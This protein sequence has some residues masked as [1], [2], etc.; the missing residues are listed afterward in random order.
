M[1]HCSLLGI[2]LQKT[3][4]CLVTCI[5]RLILLLDERPLAEHLRITVLEVLVHSEVLQAGVTD[6]VTTDVTVSLDITCIVILVAETSVLLVYDNTTHLTR[7]IR[8]TL[9]CTTVR[10]SGVGEDIHRRTELI[11]KL[12]SELCNT[13]CVGCICITLVDRSHRTLTHRE[14]AILQL[15]IGEDI[16]IGEIL[17]IHLL[18][19]NLRLCASLHI[20]N[21]RR[22]DILQPI[23]CR[24]VRVRNGRLIESST[25][26]AESNL[27]E[28]VEDGV[29]LPR[30]NI[31]H[32]TVSTVL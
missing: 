4:S 31:E 9:T 27:V 8:Q 20:H 17:D 25:T 24:V 23:V 28:A 10:A 1:Q 3:C 13:V 2:L 15:N 12:D 16:V 6:L 5:L 21:H 7:A 11:H 26:H 32:N 19:R 30:N 18:L 22:R 29:I 14:Y